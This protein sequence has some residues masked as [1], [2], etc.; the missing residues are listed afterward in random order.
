VALL[1]TWIDQPTARRGRCTALTRA[2]GGI[3]DEVP[4]SSEIEGNRGRF[5]G[6]DRDKCPNEEWEILP[7]LNVRLWPGHIRNPDVIVTR[8]GAMSQ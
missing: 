4:T 8:R 2:V 3:A 7:G 6:R 5:P 1:A